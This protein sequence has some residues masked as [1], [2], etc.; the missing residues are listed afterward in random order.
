MQ[1]LTQ[2]KR[3][4]SKKNPNVFVQEWP[5]LAVAYASLFEKQLEHTATQPMRRSTPK[6]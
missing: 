1:T 6:S 5:L 4:K 2:K 3:Q